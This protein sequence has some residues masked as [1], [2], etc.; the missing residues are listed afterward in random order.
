VD[1]SSGSG[2]KVARL[3]A[4]ARSYP[5][6]G[7]KRTQQERCLLDPRSRWWLDGCR[8]AA[9]GQL[10]TNRDTDHQT[11]CAFRAVVR[12]VKLPLRQIEDRRSLLMRV[13]ASN[14]AGYRNKELSA[15]KLAARIVRV[16]SSK[17]KR[18]R[19]FRGRKWTACRGKFD[20]STFWL[21]GVWSYASDGFRPLPWPGW[22]A[23][24]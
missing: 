4:D 17:K 18:S 3:S 19:F 11:A 6:Y 2:S 13:E 7:R 24:L 5:S 9:L 8:S 1:V 23:P 15:G 21:L 22:S 10:Q 16:L 20:A 14:D 12:P